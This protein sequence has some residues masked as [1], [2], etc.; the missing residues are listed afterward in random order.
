[1]LRAN[2]SIPAF[3]TLCTPSIHTHKHNRR[4][5]Q[6][7]ALK[8]YGRDLTEEARRGL[9]DPVVGRERVIQ[10]VVQVLLR[11]SKNN[12]VLIGDA[13]VGKTA[14]VEGIAQLLARPETA[15]RG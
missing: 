15:P 2:T 6:L 10:R 12:P 7:D 5:R 8:R 3:L 4:S 14:V 9:L 11:R 13:G 1:M